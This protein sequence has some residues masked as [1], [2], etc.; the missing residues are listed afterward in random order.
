MGV[1]RLVSEG[2]IGKD[3]NTRK[4]KG[5]KKKKKKNNNNMID[6]ICL[7]RIITPYPIT[8]VLLYCWLTANLMTTRELALLSN[9][10]NLEQVVDLLHPQPVCGRLKN[11]WRCFDAVTPPCVCALLKE[12]KEKKNRSLL[13]NA[14]FGRERER[15]YG[16]NG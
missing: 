11:V 14:C 9:K 4:C 12:R 5:E 15:E 8:R 6:N 3:R 13:N 16:E 7:Q 10:N 2:W 1:A